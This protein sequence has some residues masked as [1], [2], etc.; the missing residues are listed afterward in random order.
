MD[1]ILSTSFDTINNPMY[2]KPMTTPAICIP[3]TP[4]NIRTGKIIGVAP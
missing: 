2:T 4:L 1:T 3:V